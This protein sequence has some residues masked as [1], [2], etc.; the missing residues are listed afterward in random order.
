VL[1]AAEDL[2]LREVV[3]TRIR[4]GEWEVQIHFV[5]FRPGV[6]AIPALDLGGIR[7]RGI[8]M[9]TRS[10]LE[11]KGEEELT[12][13]RQQLVIP[14]TW[15]KVGLLAAFL[16]LFP[17]FLIFLGRKV[18]VWLAIYRERRFKKI[19]SQRIK[20]VLRRLARELLKMDGRRFFTELTRA[21]RAYLTARLAFP[22]DKATTR[23][24]RRILPLRLPADT[25]PQE[26][27]FGIAALLERGD[28]VRFGGRPCHRREME[29]ALRK[30]EELVETVEEAESR[31]E[32]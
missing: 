20:A 29:S 8:E 17:P 14:G 24:I 15:F 18:P 19:P 13:P 3:C 30:I 23:E 1:P 9:E 22:A 27:A 12:P 11:D 4:E 10:V 2:E 7:L 16:V 25:L 31:V 21:I 32:S 5:S 6:F 26:A 28:H